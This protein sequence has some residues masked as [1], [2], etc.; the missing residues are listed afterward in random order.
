MSGL[1]PHTAYAFRVRAL[2]AVGSSLSEAESFR[3]TPAPPSAPQHLQLLGATPSA[4]S[5]G[6][7]PPA[8]EHGAAVSGYQVECARLGGRST[9]VPPGAW[10]QA[11]QG[12]ERQA[13]V[14]SDD[15]SREGVGQGAGRAGGAWWLCACCC[16]HASSHAAFCAG[17]AAG[18]RPS[19][20]EP[21]PGARARRQR[22]RLGPLVRAAALLHRARRARGPGA[23]LG[24]GGGHQREGGLGCAR[25]QRRARE[26]VRPRSG[27]AR[28]PLGARL[29]RRGHPAPRAAAAGQQHLPAARAGGER[30]CSGRR[31]LCVALAAAG[32]CC[33][34][35]CAIDLGA[36]VASP[37]PFPPRCTYP[38]PTSP[39]LCRAVG[40]GPWSP[41]VS[42]QTSKAPPPPPPSVAAE[43][44]SSSSLE[45][46]WEAAQPG[47][48]Q[49]AVISYEVEAAPGPV[50][51]TC[52]A[53]SASAAL[54]GLQPGGRYSV[55]VRAVGADGAGHGE[56]G[57]PVRVE[58][59][60]PR[61]EERSAAAVAVA[62][63]GG[64]VEAPSKAHKARNRGGGQQ[65][66][67]ATA[68]VKAAV[69]K[70]PPKRGF[71]AVD[72]KVKRKVGVGLHGILF[73][74]LLIVLVGG[75]LL[76]H[77]S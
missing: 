55:R 8:A 5:L 33:R 49:A 27:G 20:G 44:S 76:L 42:V 19:G 54:A 15:G 26:R 11:Y 63:E 4:L 37:V 2:N 72:A 58:L 14:G 75:G 25:G 43:P 24:Q 32:A 6:W 71:A 18:A 52:P 38:S 3:T 68:V 31:G 61:P 40:A 53:R 36:H 13:Q 69:G 23:A 1:E 77:Y 57:A 64:A 10:K 41:E 30:R 50:R 47:P 66:P 21:L 12:P 9:S 28:G 39:F 73:L 65:Q 67:R 7:Q 45:V 48:Q 56:W 74:V 29:P 35:C 34:A 17:P 60:Q 22:V 46:R 59:P 51:A 62:A 16:V 70:G